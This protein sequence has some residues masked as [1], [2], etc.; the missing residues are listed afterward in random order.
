MSLGLGRA[1]IVLPL[2]VLADPITGLDVGASQCGEVRLCWDRDG[3]RWAL[4]IAVWAEPAQGLDPTP[5]MA[6]DE[7]AINLKAVAIQTPG[8]FAVT[9][10]N[11][12]LAQLL[13]HLRNSAV[14][15]LASWSSNAPGLAA[16]AQAGQSPEEGPFRGG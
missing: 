3:R 10:I 9:V 7:A 2:P 4:H 8:G 1:R 11:G 13:K 12:R 6:V 5:I 15:R 14:A 16:E